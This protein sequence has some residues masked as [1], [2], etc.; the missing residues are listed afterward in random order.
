MAEVLKAADDLLLA[1]WGMYNNLPEDNHFRT[2]AKP[3]LDAME[4]ALK[5]AEG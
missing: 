4:A 1:A 2:K 3:A 5:K